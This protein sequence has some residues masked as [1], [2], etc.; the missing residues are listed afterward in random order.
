MQ[1]SLSF[2]KVEHCSFSARSRT[3]PFVAQS[4]S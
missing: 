4:Q 3:F 1:N 2:E